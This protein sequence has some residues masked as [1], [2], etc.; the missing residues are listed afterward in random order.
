[1]SR[2]PTNIPSRPPAGSPA[3][4]IDRCV[5]RNRLFAELLPLV[6]AAAWGL[7]AL[8][9]ATGCG[10][11]CGLCLPYLRRMLATGETAF[12]AILPPDAE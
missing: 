8:M 5:C 6:E 1:M 10:E 12:S 3:L 4:H 7:P 9:R 2:V 11:Q